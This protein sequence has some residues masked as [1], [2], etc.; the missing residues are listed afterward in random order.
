MLRSALAG[1]LW[2]LLRR[3]A[4][5]ASCS[6]RAAC[7]A[8][9]EHQQESTDL[10]FHRA[11][12]FSPG[13]GMLSTSVM[14]RAQQEFCNYKG[15][16]MGILEMTNLDAEL[17]KHPGD[18]RTP[19][20]AMMLETEQK[21]RRVL[22]I[23]KNYRVLFMHGGAAAQF[24]AVP[25]NLLGD[26]VVGCDICDVGYWSKC[27]TAEASKYCSSIHAPVH[28]ICHN[29]L[30]PSVDTWDVRSGTAYVHM[31]MNETAEGVEFLTD[32]VWTNKPPLIADATST[33]LSRPVDVKNYG[34]IYASGGKNIPAGMAVVILRDDLLERTP[35]PNCPQVLWYNN[36][37]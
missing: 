8:S 17:G 16:G 32:P 19:V 33:L 10:E 21:L 12:N 11:F 27:A 9:N 23:P 24:S 22:E 4:I 13:P 6:A 20:Q 18:A 31:T 15:T 14:R 29:G 34:M 35:H 28:S 36:Y 5:Q 26:N 30:I 3:C 25:L 7:S 1:D 37:C 2:G